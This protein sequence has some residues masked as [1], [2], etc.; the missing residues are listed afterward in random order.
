MPAGEFFFLDPQPN[1][2]IYDDMQVRYPAWSRVAERWSVFCMGNFAHS[3]PDR[4]GIRPTAAARKAVT[5]A[6]FRYFWYLGRR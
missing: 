5:E 4:G 2:L 3:P 1:E 6:W